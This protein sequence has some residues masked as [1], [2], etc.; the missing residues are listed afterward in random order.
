MIKRLLVFAYVAAAFLLMGCNNS[1]K[2]DDGG[3]FYDEN[4]WI[5]RHMK[6][7]Y[8][9]S[10]KIPDEN[11]TNLNLTPE[12]YFKSLLYKP[13]EVLGDRFS[14][15][16]YSGPSKADAPD[17][18]ET[19]V[20][21]LGFM[22]A[23]M[24]VTSNGSGGVLYKGM[25]V[26]YVVPGSPAHGKIDRG[27][28]FTKC[29]G[30]PVSDMGISNILDL[31][32]AVLTKVNVFGQE[33]G[34]VTLN[35]AR[36]MD[37][38]V[39]VNGTFDYDEV[40]GYIVYNHFSYGSNYVFVNQ[41]QE[42]F[43]IFKDRNV[44]HL[45]LDLRYNPG[46]YVNVA[47]FLASMIAPK[48]NVMGRDVF[49]NMEYNANYGEYLKTAYG[50]DYN[51]MRFGLDMSADEIEALNLDL[52]SLHIITLGSTASSSELVVHGLKPYMAGSLRQYGRRT[53]GKN[54]GSISVTDRSGQF[55]WEL[56]PIVSRVY[57]VNWVSEYESGILPDVDI[58]EQFPDNPTLYPL[59]H[60]SERILSE[61]LL[62]INPSKA[63]ADS[64]GPLESIGIVDMGDISLKDRGIIIEN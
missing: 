32:V 45:I 42:V 33:Q 30:V 28:I 9:W 19:Y 64:G 52:E 2:Y 37:T 60:P 11:A 40:I 29:N 51:N 35:K 55:F 14:R 5:H 1:S 15:I 44:R 7:Y 25:Q 4:K 43:K 47:T 61:V 48:A 22:A 10:D 62:R 49:V 41:L 16:Y 58:S 24:V 23:S 8:L 56:N 46:G 27:D 6:Y 36:Y 12:G 3:G 54:L 20:S 26:L 13:G 39:I 57:D 18:A 31:E 17:A 50:A 38:P 63:K 53:Y 21:D 34:T 59:G